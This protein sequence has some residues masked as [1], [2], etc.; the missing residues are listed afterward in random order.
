MKPR[1]ALT[2]NGYDDLDFAVESKVIIHFSTGLT[3]VP[4][5]ELLKNDMLTEWLIF[6]KNLPL[7][8][9]AKD[10][11]YILLNIYSTLYNIKSDYDK[12]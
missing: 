8:E 11:Y 3:E 12:K 6:R 5:S 10:M 2:N 4:F 7:D 9:E 1:R